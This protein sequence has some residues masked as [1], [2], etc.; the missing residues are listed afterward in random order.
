MLNGLVL[1]IQSCWKLSD[2]YSYAA[3][4]DMTRFSMC[5][6]GA[7]VSMLNIAKMSGREKDNESIDLSTAS[8][9]CAPTPLK[10]TRDNH[11]V[12]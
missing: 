2:L 12:G 6:R 5:L 9:A 8:F 4:Y 3:L 11:S 10:M 7:G 1:S